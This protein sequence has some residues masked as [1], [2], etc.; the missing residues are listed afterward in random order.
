MAVV[1]FRWAPWEANS[2]SPDLLAKFKGRRREKWGMGWV[3]HW[4]SSNGD[5]ER[6][7]EEK[8][9]DRHPPHVR[10]PQL[11]S[12]GCACDDDSKSRVTVVH[13]KQNKV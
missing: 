1:F 12:R 10:S 9:G 4:W 6:T 3:K 5:G 13:I 7:G 2:A 11:F 8:E